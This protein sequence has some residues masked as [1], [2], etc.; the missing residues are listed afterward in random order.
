LE[1]KNNSWKSIFAYLPS[2]CRN[3]LLRESGEYQEL[4]YKI[5]NTGIRYAVT[6]P[7]EGKASGYIRIRLSYQGRK[8]ADLF[9]KDVNFN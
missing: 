2:F 1:I 5:T 8:V 7:I 3:Y 4:P 6:T 9:L